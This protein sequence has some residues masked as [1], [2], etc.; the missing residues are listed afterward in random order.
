MTNESG[1]GKTRFLKN[2]TGLWLVQESRRHWNRHGGNYSYADLERLALEA[3]AFARFIDPDDPAFIAHGNVPGHIGEYCTKTGQAPPASVGETVRCIYESLAMKYRATLEML[4]SCTGKRYPCL[5]VMGG[6]V[7][8]GLLCKMTANACG[9]PVLAGPAEATVLGNVLV[10]MVAQG[11]AGGLK[12]A[13]EV[14]RGSVEVREYGASEVEEW[15]E[16]YQRFNKLTNKRE[17]EM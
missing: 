17:A 1:C 4:A 5:H 7:K 2:I 9:V 6:G 16:G 12:E 13:R 14:V 8:D 10:Q 15:R 3:P 11:E